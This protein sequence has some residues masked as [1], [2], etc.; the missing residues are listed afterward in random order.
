MDVMTDH[1]RL[2]FFFLIA[3]ITSFTDVVMFPLVLK[4]V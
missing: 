3:F 4:A 1:P 2:V